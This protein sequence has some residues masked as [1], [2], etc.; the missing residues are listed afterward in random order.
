MNV[1]ELNV[2]VKP[3][4]A[5]MVLNED[6]IKLLKTY[7]T[8]LFSEVIPVIKRFMVFDKD[9]LDNCF[10]VV[11]RKYDFVQLHVMRIWIYIVHY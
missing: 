4:Y 9:N 5:K 8:L 1:G 11:P 7:H 3:D 6:D 2:T 10:L